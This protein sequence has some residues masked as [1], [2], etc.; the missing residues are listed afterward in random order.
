MKPELP[1]SILNKCVC[2]KTGRQHTK[3]RAPNWTKDGTKETCES[4]IQVVGSDPSSEERQDDERLFQVGEYRRKGKR[5]AL[6]GDL[7]TVEL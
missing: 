4:K 3:T 2:L 7:E 5:G 1:R 6:E